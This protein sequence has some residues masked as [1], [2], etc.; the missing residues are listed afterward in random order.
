MKL[1]LLPLLLLGA[2]AGAFGL[3]S[4]DDSQCTADDCRI[5]VECTERG[6]CLVTC[7]EADGEVRCQQEVPC[8]EPCEATPAE[9][10]GPKCAPR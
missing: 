2:A 8:D 10:C 7:Y 9:D 1:L 5:T 4:T 6:T 3:G